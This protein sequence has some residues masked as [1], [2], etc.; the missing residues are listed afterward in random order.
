MVQRNQWDCPP[1]PPILSAITF[2]FVG[3][4][5]VVFLTVSFTQQFCYIEGMVIILSTVYTL[6]NVHRTKKL[7]IYSMT[8]ILYDIYDVGLVL[9][10][11]TSPHS[12]G[13]SELPTCS[14]SRKTLRCQLFAC[15]EISTPCAEMAQAKGAA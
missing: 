1:P 12:S 2:C 10:H 13:D 3:V 8:K 9:T 14:I 4:S 11:T 6:G 5:V 15:C 7:E